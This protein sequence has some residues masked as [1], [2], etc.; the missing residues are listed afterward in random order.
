MASPQQPTGEKHFIGWVIAGL[1]IV[2][3]VLFFFLN[4]QYQTLRREQIVSARRS[5]IM[6][7]IKNHPHLTASD[8]GIIRSWMTFD[9]LNSSF[10][11][12]ATYLK[13]QLSISDPTYPKL[14][15]GKFAKDTNQSASSTLGA[16]QNAVRQYLSAPVF[17]NTS[18]T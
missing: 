5:W 13:T 11:L 1:G 7:A 18:S 3:V 12:P 4:R 10:N 16:V 15:I 14:T 9:Y 2:L 8:A 6:N 17:K